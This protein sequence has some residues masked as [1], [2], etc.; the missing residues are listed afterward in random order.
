MVP[1]ETYALIGGAV[2][3]AQRFELTLTVSVEFFRMVT[4][5]QYRML[6]KGFVDPTRFKIPL[7]KLIVLLSEK[8]QIAPELEA[9][10]LSLIERRHVLVHRW[11]RE[12]GFP[13]HDDVNDWHRLGELAIGVDR[14]SIDSL[15]S[16][17]PT[18]EARKARLEEIAT[19]Q[20]KLKTA[21]ER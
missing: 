2:C 18:E 20:K 17:L 5:P 15:N 11:F 12:N 3:A 6:T 10:I 21:L 14:D 8:N 13:S 16:S 1:V 7:K 9:Q 4:E 19:Q